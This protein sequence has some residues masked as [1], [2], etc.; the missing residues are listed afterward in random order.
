[1]NANAAGPNSI[2]TPGTANKTGF[3]LSYTTMATGTGSAALANYPY[4]GYGGF[5]ADAEL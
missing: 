5:T 3:Q 2:T 4:Q 1:M